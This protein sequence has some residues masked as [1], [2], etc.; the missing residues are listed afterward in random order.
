MRSWQRRRLVDD[1]RRL[2]IT[3]APH[4]VLLPEAFDLAT[5]ASHPVYDCLYLA[6][7]HQSDCQLVTADRRFYKAFAQH[8]WGRYMTWIED[9]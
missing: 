9:Q 3:M 1:L 7:A 5:K 6:L 2:E 8:E 4:H